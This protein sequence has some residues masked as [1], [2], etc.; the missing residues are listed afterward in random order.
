MGRVMTQVNAAKLPHELIH[1][2]VAPEMTNV[3][4][5]LNEFGQREAPLT[6]HL[7]NLVPDAALDVVEL[8]QSC[9]HRTSPRQPCTLSPSEPVAY[10]RLQ[11]GK[12]FVGFYRGLDD[13]RHRKFR[14]MG[15]QFDLNVLFRSEVGE[16]PAFRHS[17]LLGQDS[18]GNA[19]Q[20]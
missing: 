11:T 7:E 8:E 4:G 19:G 18:K 6:L 14:H 3:H 15:Q 20:A 1:I 12:T 5:A 13:M 9:C 2:E 17:D 16:Q 10:E